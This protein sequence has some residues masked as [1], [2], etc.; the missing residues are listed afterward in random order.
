MFL[1]QV[2]EDLQTEANESL[3]TDVTQ[4]LGDLVRRRTPGVKVTM[5]GQNELKDAM[6]R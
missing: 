5:L 4:S 2:L 1:F 3:T 6:L